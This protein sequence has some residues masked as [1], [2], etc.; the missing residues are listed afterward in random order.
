MMGNIILLTERK[1]R[2][3]NHNF[4]V[5]HIILSNILFDRIKKRCSNKEEETRIV[6]K[7]LG[8]TDFYS[9]SVREMNDAHGWRVTK[10]W[11]CFFLEKKG[12]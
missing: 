3:N 2:Y 11:F 9:L 10:R 4:K 5:F 8:K 12:V 6:T 7:D 1:N